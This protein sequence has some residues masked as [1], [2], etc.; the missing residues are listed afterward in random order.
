VALSN[1]F[2]SGKVKRERDKDSFQGR[3]PCKQILDFLFSP[4]KA[5]MPQTTQRNKSQVIGTR[6]L[7]MLVEMQ[8][9]ME[10]RKPNRFTG[11][12]EVVLNKRDRYVM[13]VEPIDRPVLLL[14]GEKIQRK[15]SWIVYSHIDLETYY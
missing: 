4:S 7:V 8:Y 10:L 6:E 5:V 12:V 2:G 14:E 1:N 15:N 13:E 3:N 9:V 11:I